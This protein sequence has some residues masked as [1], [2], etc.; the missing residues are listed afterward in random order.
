MI[1]MTWQQAAACAGLDP[2]AFDYPT[3]LSDTVC[4]GCPVRRECGANGMHPSQHAAVKE[5]LRQEAWRDYENANSRAA[6]A[7]P[8]IRLVGIPDD[9]RALH[10]EFVAARAAGREPS[11]EA[12]DGERTYQQLR[13]IARRRR[14]ADAVERALTEAPGRAS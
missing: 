3:T 4:P 10:A 2:R 1:D 9:V 8:R 14:D 11:P 12:H 6:A 5:R 13:H 7:A